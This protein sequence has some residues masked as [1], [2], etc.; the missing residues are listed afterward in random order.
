MEILSRAT[1]DRIRCQNTFKHQVYTTMTW[2]DHDSEDHKTKYIN[3]YKHNSFTILSSRKTH[4]TIYKI[5]QI[6]TKATSKH[7]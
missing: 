6:K 2:Y 3:G 5:N 7:E 4:T 1:K